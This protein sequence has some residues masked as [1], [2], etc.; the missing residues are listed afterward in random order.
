[1]LE[2]A[3]RVAKAARAVGLVILLANRVIRDG[4][5]DDRRWATIHE[6]SEIQIGFMNRHPVGIRKK[7]SGF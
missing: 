1:M 6:D 2:E 3:E 7:Q 5:G 4:L